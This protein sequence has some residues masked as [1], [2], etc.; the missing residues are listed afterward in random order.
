MTTL[1]AIVVTYNRLAQLQKTLGQLLADFADLIVVVDSGSTDGSREWLRGQ[2]D[3]RL[4][5]IERAE[6]GGGAAGFEEGLRQA[7]ARFNPDWCV[8]MDDDARPAPGTLAR[9]KSNP[10]GA[11]AVAAAVRLPGGALCEMNRP[12][13]NPFW[14]PTAFF[15]AL[16][17]GRAGFHL[18]D[19]A[20]KP[21]AGLCPIDGASFVGLFLSRRAVELAGYPEGGLFIYGDDVLYTLGLSAAGGRLLCDPALVFEHDCAQEPPGALWQPLWKNYYLL[22]NRAFVYRQAAGPLF[23]PLLTAL[24]LRKAARRAAQIPEGPDRTAYLALLA[25]AKADAKADRR[26]RPHGEVLAALAAANG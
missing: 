12:W 14:R 11:E 10:P 18:S 16:L 1:A 5:L 8:L 21:E 9:F 7:M 13:R 23:G 22:R 25:L 4:C 15:A 6:N 3:P 19:A 20:L 24:M 2:A 17:R 26:H